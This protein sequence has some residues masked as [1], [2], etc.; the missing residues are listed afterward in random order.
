M[1]VVPL[2]FSSL[3]VGVAGIGDHQQQSQEELAQ[4]AGD[5]IHHPHDARVIAAK[6]TIDRDT[7]YNTDRQPDQDT[8]MQRHPLRLI[9]RLVVKISSDLTLESIRRQLNPLR[10]LLTFIGHL[11]TSATSDEWQVTS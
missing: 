5:V 8:R 6:Q 1:I 4:R 10:L 9:R 11:L 2:V 3:V 7:C